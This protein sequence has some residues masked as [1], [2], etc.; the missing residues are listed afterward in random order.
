MSTVSVIIPT[1]DRLEHVQSVVRSLSQQTVRAGQIIVVDQSHKNNATELPGFVTYL[2]QK[3]CG[4]AA[5]RNLGVHEARYEILLFVDDD[6]EIPSRNF[7]EN[8]IR[9]YQYSFVDVVHGGVRQVDKCLPSEP[10][11]PERL[12]AA[13]W[14]RRSPNCLRRQMCVGLAGGNFSIRRELFLR[15][16]GFDERFD[17]GEDIELGIRLFR[18]GAVM[19]YDPEPVIVH[20]RSSGGTRSPES[21]C[22][23]HGLFRPDPHPGEYLLYLKH[24]PGW[25]ARLWI[26]ERLFRIWT[27]GNLPHAGRCILQTIRLWQCVREARGL[28][29]KNG[30]S[31]I[32]E[33]A[34]RA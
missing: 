13:E 12:T 15:V 31:G 8:H 27:H 29:K 4:P 34:I 28:S 5:G 14:L 18:A 21:P 9:W 2:H 10:D 7:I 19:I 32:P 20:L 1:L 3:A 24:F 6:A 33:D 11:W 16:G 30:V 25:Q 22:Y 23:H 26:I 17:R